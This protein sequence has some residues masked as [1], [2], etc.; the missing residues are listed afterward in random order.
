GTFCPLNAITLVGVIWTSSQEREFVRSLGIYVGLFILCFS[1][2]AQVNILTAN[3][4]NDRTNANLQETLL[5]PATVN[6]T[7]FGKLGTLSVD[8]QIYAQPLVVSG[9]QV[10]GSTRNVVFVSTMH[11]SVYAFDA[12]ATSPVS[13]LWHVNLGNPVPASLLFRQ[14]G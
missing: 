6:S 8:G 7:T 9:L 1:S 11:N 2:P 4:N 13:T 3:G 14:Y 10:A 12:D 5:S